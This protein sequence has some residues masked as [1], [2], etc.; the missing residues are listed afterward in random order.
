MSIQFDIRGH[1]WPVDADGCAE[2]PANMFLN[3]A[4][5]NARD[6][7]RW[8]GLDATELIGEIS[9]RELAP[10][11]RRRLWP[12]RV[13]D[14]DDELP[15]TVELLPSAAI[16]IDLGRPAG[17]LAQYA[18]RLLHLAEFAGDGVIGWG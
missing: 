13:S 8:I 12:E 2:P 4:E 6:F 14:G 9:A 11:L 1:D 5:V 7:L 17:R 18:Q 16:L 10:I 3:I 15:V